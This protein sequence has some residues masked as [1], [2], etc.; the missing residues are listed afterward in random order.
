MA[1]NE[2]GNVKQENTVGPNFR[3]TYNNVCNQDGTNKFTVGKW[4]LV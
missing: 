2:G 3:Y 4:N 1:E